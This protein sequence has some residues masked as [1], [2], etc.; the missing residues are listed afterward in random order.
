[1]ERG[2]GVVAHKLI[3][4]GIALAVNTRADFAAAILI[5]RRLVHDLPGDANGVAKLLPVLLMG[6]IV[7]Q[8]RRMG[9][10]VARLQT[11]VAAAGGTHRADVALEA[12]LFHRV[13]AIV[14]NRH[15]QEMVLNV[16]PGELC[17]AA[18]KTARFELVAGADPGAAEQP[19]GADLRLVPPLQRRVERH[20]LFALVLQ[21]HLQMVLQILTHAGEIVDHR[22]IELPEQ[23]GVADAGALQDL[24]R[25]NRPGAQ[26]HLFV[27]RRF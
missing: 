20:R 4:L 22:D 13:G 16:R 12:V 9:V 23:L 3:Q 6:H 27:G 8:D 11:H 26:Q 25:G 17:A 1:M 2:L 21:V 18:D 7:K 19:L 24:R 5:Q 14:V 15:R 10:R